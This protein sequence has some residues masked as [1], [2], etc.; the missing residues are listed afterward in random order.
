MIK[1]IF[2][3]QTPKLYNYYGVNNKFKNKYIDLSFQNIE[4]DDNIK[5]FLKILDKIHKLIKK[6]YNTENFIRIYK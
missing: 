1:K 4:N 5:D 6:V 3:I 2:V